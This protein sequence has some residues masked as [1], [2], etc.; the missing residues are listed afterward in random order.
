MC[1]LQFGLCAVFSLYYVRDSVPLM[2]SLSSVLCA[3]SSL[4]YVQFTLPSLVASL[5]ACLASH[6][7]LA[8]LTF[9][10]STNTRLNFGTFQ[11]NGHFHKRTY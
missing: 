2:C 3:V 11:P 10:S 5:R 7:W 6:A 8:S 1:S 4:C 9:G